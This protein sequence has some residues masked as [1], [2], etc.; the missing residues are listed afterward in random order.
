MSLN[1]T[2]FHVIAQTPNPHPPKQN[3]TMFFAP[4]CSLT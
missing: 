1:D 4:Y 2:T 3:L